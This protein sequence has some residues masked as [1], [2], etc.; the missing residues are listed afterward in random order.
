MA[1]FPQKGCGIMKKL[2]CILAVFAICLT[3][4]S[5][6]FALTSDGI[7]VLSIGYKDG[8]NIVDVEDFDIEHLV[9]TSLK[10]AEE[11]TTDIYQ[12]DRDL[13]WSVY[14]KLMD[15]TMELPL[16]EDGTY[17]VIRELL[18]VS[19]TTEC[20]EQDDHEEQLAEEGVTI[21]ITFD[22]GVDADTEVVVMT[23]VDGE[24]G[25][26]ISVVNNGDGTVTCVFEDICPVVF[27]VEKG[28]D[29]IQTG[30]TAGRNLIW[31]IILMVVSTALLVY[32][33]SKRRKY[34]R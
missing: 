10:A 34:A 15:G 2:I 24:W 31:W 23:F 27:C 13:L 32:M 33:I 1:W 29:N 26:I 16:E 18:D 8:A 9:V 14:L 3:F 12:E 6:A 25:H 30:D 17:Y 22:L 20:R 19:F 11:K 21:T 5:P 4:I 28:S 7:F